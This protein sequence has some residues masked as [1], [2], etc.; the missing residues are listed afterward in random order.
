MAVQD[1]MLRK[2][3]G[4]RGL[5]VGGGPTR[6]GTKGLGGWR[7]QAGEGAFPTEVGQRWNC[8]APSRGQADHMGRGRWPPAHRGR[9]QRTQLAARERLRCTFGQARDGPCF[10]L[11]SLKKVKTIAKR[12]SPL[13]SR[14]R[15][16]ARPE[17]HW[18]GPE[19][20]STRGKNGVPRHVSIATIHA[21]KSAVIAD[22]DN[23]P[24]P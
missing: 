3:E 17:S 21:Y 5:P 4:A 13:P 2:P 20:T 12:L 23:S 16:H 15:V 22:G 11:V 8:V 6:A 14:S 7:G 9:L 19:L 24:K 10:P 18:S 1:R